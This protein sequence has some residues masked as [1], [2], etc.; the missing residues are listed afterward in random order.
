MGFEYV[1][2]DL[3]GTLLNT[4]DDLGDCCNRVC[5]SHGWPEH[6][7]Q[8]YKYFVGRGMRNLVTCFVPED[9]RTPERVQQVLDEYMPIY[10]AHKEDKTAPYPGIPLLLKRLTEA[11]VSIAVLSNKAHSATEPIIAHYFPGRFPVVQGAVDGLPLKPD[12]ALVFRLMERMGARPDRTLFVG[13]SDVDVQTA[14]NAGLPVC[15]VLW[16]FR[17]RKELEAAGADC[18]AAAPEELADRILGGRS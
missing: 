7:I 6:T 12:P 4:I 13:D 14:R 15:A 1:I 3:D 5:R 16:G 11:G 18:F 9:W 17:T 10:A 2:F 8:E